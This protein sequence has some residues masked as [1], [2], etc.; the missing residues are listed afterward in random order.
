MAANRKVWTP[1]DVVTVPLSSGGYAYGRVLDKLMAFYDLRTSDIVPAEQV[2]DSAVLFV[3]SVHT[4]AVTGGRWRIIGH[5]PLEDAFRGETKFFRP[6]P[7]AR[8][9]RIYVSKPTPRNAY[10]EYPAQAADCVGLEPLLAW[11]AHLME[12]RLEDH[13]AGRPNI[14]LQHEMGRLLRELPRNA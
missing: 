8:G 1:G 9:F 5:S 11:D 13:C 6:D 7:S 3:T 14:H 12:E 10:E 4:A 2:M